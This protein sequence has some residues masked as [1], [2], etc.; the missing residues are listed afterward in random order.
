MEVETMEDSHDREPDE[1]RLSQTEMQRQE[2]DR[3]EGRVPQSAM[4]R[5]EEE[6]EQGTN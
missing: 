2:D 5:D 6:K 4:Q 3:D 1:G